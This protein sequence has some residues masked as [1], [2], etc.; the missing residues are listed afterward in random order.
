MKARI[1]NGSEAQRNADRGQWKRYAEGNSTADKMR[2]WRMEA[3]WFAGTRD[4]GE[5]TAVEMLST[6]P[7]ATAKKSRRRLWNRKGF[8]S[9][10][11]ASWQGWKA[12]WGQTLLR[13]GTQTETQRQIRRWWRLEVCRYGISISTGPQAKP[14]KEKN[15]DGYANDWETS[16]MKT[17]L[18]QMIQCV[19]V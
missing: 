1:E 8:T 3:R 15:A 7:S 4:G 16:T 17:I 2:W 14:Q 13:A 11:A 9:T 12:E 6:W 18:K 10:W 19:K 5:A